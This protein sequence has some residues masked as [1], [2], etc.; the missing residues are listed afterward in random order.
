MKVYQ[1][2]FSSEEI[3]SD[4]FNIKLLF[5]ETCGEVQANWTNK[6]DVNVDIGCGNAFGA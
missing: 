6:G 5:N 2:A 4:S 3:V 1:D